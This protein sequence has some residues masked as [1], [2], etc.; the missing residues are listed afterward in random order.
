MKASSNFAFLR[1]HDVELVRLGTLA[2]RS[3]HSDPVACLFRLRLY[4]EFLAK[5]IAARVGLYEDADE[6]QV[7]L[8]NRLRDRGIIH[9]Q[10]DRFFYELRKTGNQ[11]VHHS[12]G[13]RRT[14]LSILKY[15]Q[16]LGIWYH[17]T[18]GKATDFIAPEYCEPTPPEVTARQ[19]ES[20]LADER[21]ARTQAEQLAAEVAKDL[22]D[23][24]QHLT[25]IQ[26]QQAKNSDANVK[27]AIARSQ[28]AEAK[29]E[30]DERETRRLI[31][32]QLR[33][34]GWEVDS[35]EWTYGK[36]TRP[37][38]HRNLAIAEYPTR[39]GSADYALFV[40]LQL[41]GIIEAKRE[42]KDV[43]GNID[44]A[45]RYARSIR[46]S[47]NLQFA[48][49]APWGEDEP[50]QVPFVF[51]TNGR[52]YLAQL[53]T[54]SGIWF[55]DV[56]RATNQR[57]AIAGWYSPVGLIDLLEQDFD[58]AHEQL[59]QEQFNYGFELRHY[60]IK[61]IAAI[62]DALKQDRRSLLLAMATGTG[63]TKTCIALIYR[64]LKTKRFRRVLFL[65]DR[66][67]LGQQ[68]IAA[69]K[70]TR[71]ELQQVFTDIYE[72]KELKD[73][74]CDRDTKVHVATVQSFVK[75]I[76]Y[77][78]D[79][80]SSPNVDDYDCVIIDECHRGYLLDRELNSIELEFRDFDDYVSKYR[81][82][83][84]YFDAVKIGITATPALHT[85]EIFGEPIFQYTYAEAV[86]DKCLTDYESPHIIETE[87]AKSG[88]VWEKGAEIEVL[89]PRTGKRDLN[90]TADEVKVEIKH[91]NKKVITPA[92]NRVVCEYLAEQI[93]PMLAEK[94]LIFCANNDHADLV[95]QL[96][97]EALIAK[98][99]EIE[100]EAVRKITGESD[101]PL[102]L[103][104]KYKN[105]QLPNIAVTVDLL[106]TGIDVPTICN[107]VFLR[108][109]NSRILFEQML[110]R[111]TRLCPEIGK[112]RFRVFDAVNIF[113]VM[114]QFT[115]MK[116][117]AMI[118]KISCEKLVDELTRT[119]DPRHHQQ[120]LPQLFAKI[121][122]KLRRAN[123]AKR[124]QLSAIA[125]VSLDNLL[126]D[127][128]A[129]QPSQLANWFRDRPDF[130]STIDLPD[131][132]TNPILISYHSDRLVSVQRG[133]GV[134]E[135]G[136]IYST[137]P[138]EYLQLFQKFLTDNLNLIPALM[139]AVQ[140]P[141]DLTRAQLKELQMLLEENR[142]KESDLQGAWRD[143]K[144]EDIAASIIGFI[145]QAALG[146]ALI[147]YSD[148]VDRAIRKILKSRSW[149]A[150]QRQ[151]LERIAKQLKAETIV[152]REALDRGAFKTE[153]GG[154]TRLNKTFNGELLAVL[155]SINEGIWHD[156]G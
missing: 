114:S 156:I 72:V 103:I 50:F 65:V 113:G 151:L 149:A 150:P 13:D 98:Y 121:H 54:K 7:Q 17:R 77:P 76:M 104:L 35:E 78:S 133:Y 111:A 93:D 89:D 92:F 58:L 146:D 96:L 32:T 73:A 137:R 39:T 115:E 62:E 42:S 85:S 16:Q 109:V 71:M 27:I 139:V 66:T 91:F 68:A 153:C 15:A 125:G 124:E 87:L 63:K 22:Q 102:E 154:F 43:S 130:A 116:P 140:S 144:N 128:R 110:G 41:V 108:R 38:K 129:S 74:S 69:F 9:G 135:D 2:E 136:S 82:V 12:I 99:G 101:R 36:G 88:I 106:T 11:A 67:S 141:K 48:K 147:P 21:L 107:I 126:D 70:E 10:I 79:S 80:S 127:L 148:R 61:A 75:R 33:E 90:K 112:D 30:L 25:E 138:D 49:G 3:Y 117:V 20:A 31:D 97:K 53:E 56:R 59:A 40:G 64:L 51:A 28:A 155:E 100:D 60:Q 14:A 83:V 8:L 34:V 47:D 134:A 145:R 132:R 52:P 45:H 119:S 19:L 94:T 1:E 143:R 46:V 44:Q 18:W 4:G 131:D 24:L 152:D 29:V 55:R 122:R 86:I 142:F 57:R 23:A 81:R 95:V 118:P 120:I 37:V 123:P 105:E 26:A 84:E 6:S 5:L